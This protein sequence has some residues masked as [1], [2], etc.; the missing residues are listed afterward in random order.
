[1]DIHHLMM[2]DSKF[3]FIVFSSWQQLVKSTITRLNVNNTQVELSDSFRYVG[4]HLKKNLNFRKRITDKCKFASFNLF[5]IRN[6][7]KYLTKE[8]CTDIVFGLVVVHLDYEKGLFL[9]LP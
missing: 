7:Q 8:P 4:V 9:D 2:N 1:M 5:Q 6:I 3:E